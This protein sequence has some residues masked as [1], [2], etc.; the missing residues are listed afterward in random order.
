VTGPM[1]GATADAAARWWRAYQLAEND[2]VDELRRLAAAGDEEASR[3]L[4][5]W[6]SDRAYPRGMA[7]PAKLEEAIEV[8]RPVA[9]AGDDVADRWLARWL[10][11]CD[12]LDQLRERAAA[13][14]DHASRELARLLA[15]HDLL[16]ELR[17]R[18]AAT[19]DPYALR[20]LARRL[21]ERDLATDLRHLLETADPDNRQ[22]ILDSVAG[23]SSAWPNAVRVLA[24]FGH[25]P[26]QMHLTTRAPAHHPNPPA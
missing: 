22:L 7:D 23:A 3:Q 15:D 17:A 18:A 16:D 26:S 5:G 25:R 1:H 11:D 9:D 4:A 24:A 20:E 10:A 8:I 13:D 12:R 2:Q 14:S 6:L 21:I 19:D